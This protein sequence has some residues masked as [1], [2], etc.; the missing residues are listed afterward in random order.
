MTGQGVKELSVEGF[1]PTGRDEQERD[2]L[3]LELEELRREIIG[4]CVAE[5]TRRVTNAPVSEAPTLR[6]L[7]EFLKVVGSIGIVANVH[8]SALEALETVNAV[9]PLSADVR[10]MVY[11]TILAD[12]KGEGGAS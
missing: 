3:D 12:M 11:K 9:H 5:L 4:A 10:K 2:P 6:E 8:A 1:V 7:C